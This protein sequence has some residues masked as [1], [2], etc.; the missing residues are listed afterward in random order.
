MLV[1]YLGIC[2]GSIIRLGNVIMF[3][4]FMEVYTLDMGIRLGITFIVGLINI[5]NISINENRNSYKV[6]YNYNVRIFN[7]LTLY[8]TS[9]YIN[10]T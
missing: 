3:N 6:W 7:R 5:R 4:I 10:N 2:L 8:N 1:I 9:L